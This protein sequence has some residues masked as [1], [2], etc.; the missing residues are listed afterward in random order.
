[1]SS[2]SSSS[3][4][5]NNRMNTRKRRTELKLNELNEEGKRVLGIKLLEYNLSNLKKINF[6]FHDDQKL[7]AIHVI[8]LMLKFG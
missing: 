5:D 2:S 7:N 3:G 6:E 1:M 4:G 8:T